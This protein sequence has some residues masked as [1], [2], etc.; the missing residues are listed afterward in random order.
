MTVRIAGGSLRDLTYI[1]GNLRPADRNEIECQ[2]AEWDAPLIALRCMQGFAY[3]AELNGNPEAAFG[4]IE[5][6]PGLWEAWSWGTRKMPRCI[7]EIT[8]FFFAVLGPDVA[9]REAW[10]VEARPSA[11]NDLASRWLRKLGATERCRLP[12][13]GKNGEDFKL[14]DWTRES[15]NVFR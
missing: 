10:R 13:F 6:R 14:F 8:R 15:W 3:V 11:D 2:M 4:A 12:R 5:Q 7:P 9:S 1:L